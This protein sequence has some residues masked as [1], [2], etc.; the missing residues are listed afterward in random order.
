PDGRG[1][2]GRELFRLSDLLEMLP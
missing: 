1:T 2:D